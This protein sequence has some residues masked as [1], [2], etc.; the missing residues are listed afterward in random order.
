MWLSFSAVYDP[1]YSELSEGREDNTKKE[2]T[3]IAVL[4]W[5][6]SIIHLSL[7]ALAMLQKFPKP[8]LTL[9]VKQNM[10]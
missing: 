10:C 3:E 4:E 6:V 8:G 9:S 5:K 7:L 2:L 1:C